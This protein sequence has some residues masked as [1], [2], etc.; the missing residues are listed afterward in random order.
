MTV[1]ATGAAIPIVAASN[2]GGFGTIALWQEEPTSGGGTLHAQHLLVGGDLDPAWPAAGAVVC[3][4]VAARPELGA[5]TDHLGGCYVWWSEG[6]A[7]ATTL[8]LSRLAADGSVAAGWPA[9]GLNL[10]PIH[11]QSPRPS[12]IEDGANGVYLAWSTGSIVRGSHL[13]PNG[14]GAGG[15]PNGYRVL[16]ASAGTTYYWP[17]LGLAPGGVFLSWAAVGPDTTGGNGMYLR[18]LTTAGI[19]AA[20]WTVDGIQ[21]GS[22]RPWVLP[23]AASAPLISIDADGRGGLF[24]FLGTLWLDPVGQSYGELRLHRLLGDGQP[25]PDWPVDG[26]VPSVLPNPYVYDGT[27]GPDGGVRVESNGVD[28]AIVEARYLYSDSPAITRVAGC[29]AA[30]DWSW[31]LDAVTRGH[32][33]LA[34]GDGGA[35]VADFKPIGPYSVWDWGAFLKVDQSAAAPG[36]S[37]W[38]E[39]HNEPAQAWFGDIAL[40]TAGPGSA[41]FFWSQSNL[42]QGLFARRFGPL[43]P[44]TGVADEPSALALRRLRFAAGAGVVASLELDGTPSRLELYDLAGRRLATRALIGRGPAEVALP[45]SSGLAAGVYF[46]R[47]VS[48]R[49]RAFGKLAVLR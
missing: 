26:R 2:D 31:A 28:G 22:F 12:A 18:R 25:G 14:L 33:A 9:R 3:D 21:V 37:A 16:L 36:W 29:T 7:V 40:A 10:G 34:K 46:A 11:A 17:D 47:L 30:G 42:Q 38:S 44:T 32:Q 13:G 23:F 43:G 39:W 41:V 6:P 19:N 15:W 35:F 45:E 49:A 8:F 48:S 20:G 5:V 24:L 1:R 4:V 27:G